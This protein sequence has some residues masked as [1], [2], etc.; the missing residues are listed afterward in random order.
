MTSVFQRI[1]LF[2]GEALSWFVDVVGEKFVERR[3]IFSGRRLFIKR[4][5]GELTQ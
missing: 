2:F 3:A 4:G 1:Q 5:S